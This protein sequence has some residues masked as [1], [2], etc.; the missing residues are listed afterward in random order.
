MLKN[1][2]LLISGSLLLLHAFIPHEHHSELDEIE[3]I[4][5]H[6]QA[7]GLFDLLQLV[8]HTD[9]GDEH[10]ENF[11]TAS[12]FFLQP[13][14]FDCETLTRTCQFVQSEVRP[15]ENIS[16]SSIEEIQYLTFRGPPV[17]S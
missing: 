7:D 1:I 4:Q 14:L 8:F 9:L 3:H 5:Q 11:K 15:R 10:L 16:Y 6:Q 2:P 13:D 12:Y 17:L